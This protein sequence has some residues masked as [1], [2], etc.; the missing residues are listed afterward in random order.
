MDNHKK[1]Y[2]ENTHIKQLQ[3]TVQSGLLSEET[4]SANSSRRNKQAKKV[5][6]QPSLYIGFLHTDIV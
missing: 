6:A 3:Q 2:N 4:E 5:K 1:V